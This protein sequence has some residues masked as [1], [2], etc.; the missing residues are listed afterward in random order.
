MGRDDADCTD[1]GGVRTLG[2]AGNIRHVF[3]TRITRIFLDDTD[4]KGFQ[5]CAT[6]NIQRRIIVC[7]RGIL[8]TRV[9]RG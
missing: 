4:G 9:I 6:K 1:G 7:I 8:D 3:L 5:C 2:T